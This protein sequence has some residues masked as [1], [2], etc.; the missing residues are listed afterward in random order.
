MKV[1]DEVN[2]FFNEHIAPPHKIISVR[3]REEDDKEGYRAL[4]EVIEEKEY[5]KKYANDQMVGLYE[6][7]LNKES[8]VTGFSR[9]SLR[10]RSDLEEQS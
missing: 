10:Y 2:Q 3:E 9:I 8:E 5:M 1:M 4:V 6:V 7:F